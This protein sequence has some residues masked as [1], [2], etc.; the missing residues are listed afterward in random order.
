MKKKWSVQKNTEF[1][2]LLLFC[3]ICLPSEENGMSK[4]RLKNR[5]LYTIYPENRKAIRKL[6]RKSKMRIVDESSAVQAFHLLDK[7]GLLK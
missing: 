7:S 2:F 4:I 1:L 6:L 3:T 5:S